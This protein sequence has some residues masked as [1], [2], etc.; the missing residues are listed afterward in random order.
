MIILSHVLTLF[1]DTA[2]NQ[3]GLALC[4]NKETLSIRSLPKETDT[5]LVPAIE[6]ILKENAKTYGD[7]TNLACVTGPGGFTSLRVGIATINALAYTLRIPST[8]IHLS[9]LWRA[10]VKSFDSNFL[11]L[12]STRR[13]QIFAKKFGG[14]KHPIELL[15]IK[16]IA[17]IRGSY[18]G[19]LL[20]EHKKLLASCTPIPEN[21]LLPIE[22]MLPKFLAKLNYVEMQLLPWYG[23]C[24]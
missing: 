4:E 23:R 24:E 13:T 8:G 5:V 15:D 17:N 14:A 9:E 18:V 12:H 2:S 19:E 21:D 6:N 16:D 1:L 10:R 3:H 11:W 7:L 22:E 20:P